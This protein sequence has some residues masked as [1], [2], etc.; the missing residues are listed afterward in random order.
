MPFAEAKMPLIPNSSREPITDFDILSIRFPLSDGDKSVWG[1]VSE[2]ALRERAA[3][4]GVSGLN[5][6]ELFERYRPKL[7]KLASDLYDEGKHF[8]ATDGA[9]VVRVPNGVL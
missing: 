3:Q 8:T 4:D 9:V 5:K 6:M 7:E 2:H 1:E